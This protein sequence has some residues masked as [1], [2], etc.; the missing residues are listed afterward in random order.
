MFTGGRFDQSIWADAKAEGADFS[1]ASLALSVWHRAHCGGAAFARAALQ[2][3]DFS[4]ADLTRADLRGA[5]FLRTRM[6]RALQE[7][8][9][10]SGR[11]GL[12]E[13]DAELHKA[14][15]WSDTRGGRQAPG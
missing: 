1:D 2:D 3:A 10:F 13:Q 7:G 6:H 15:A 4:Y 11:G 8:A 9:H 5:Q 12:I 14:Q